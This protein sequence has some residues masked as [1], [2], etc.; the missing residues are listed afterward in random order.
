M[1]E[2]VSSKRAAVESVPHESP[3]VPNRKI[4]RMYEGMVESRMLDDL[5]RKRYGK[6]AW[7][8]TR[9]QEAC[10]ISAL[11]DLSP[12][13]LTS[14]LAGS[15][16][17]AFLRGADIDAIVASTDSKEAASATKLRQ[18]GVLP[19]S[20]DA[21]DR[22]G[23][24]LGAALA[25]KQTNSSKVVVVFADRYEAKPSEW[26]KTLH[27]ASREELPILFVVLPESPGKSTKHGKA[28]DLG[29][30]STSFGVPGIPVDASDSIA[31]YRV[32]Q[33]S[34]GR[35]RAG[36]GPALMDCVS[37]IRDGQKAKKAADPIEALAQT[38]LVRKICNKEWLEEVS[39]GFRARLALLQGA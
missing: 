37:F 3:L 19:T 35:A 11:L 31:L 28:H 2:K 36:G 20:P 29:A 16:A 33:E 38:L 14:D 10:R 1:A 6:A 26:K 21:A 24:A 32:A 7:P 23:H 17:T 25:L 27:F 18:P 8:G 12:E 30:R 34:I 9:G 13:D 15:I 5:L 22:F 39:S 4:Q